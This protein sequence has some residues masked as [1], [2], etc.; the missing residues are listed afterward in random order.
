MSDAQELL[1]K[2][3][4]LAAV[5]AEIVAKIQK[6][7]STDRLIVDA[8]ILSFRLDGAQLLIDEQQSTT[9]A[10]TILSSWR[11]PTAPKFA[12]DADMNLFNDNVDYKV[13]NLSDLERLNKKIAEVAAKYDF[14]DAKKSAPILRKFLGN[15][16]TV[17]TLLG[18]LDE[19]FIDRTD[20]GIAEIKEDAAEITRAIGELAKKIEARNAALGGNG[21]V[22]Q[23]PRWLQ[24]KCGGEIKIDG[25]AARRVGRSGWGG[26]VMAN[27]VNAKVKFTTYGKQDH[28]LWGGLIGVAVKSALTGGELKPYS[29]PNVWFLSLR[30]G[31]KVNSISGGPCASQPYAVAV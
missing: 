15:L 12:Q 4:A 21:R 24:E 30:S 3:A 11:P 14:L 19:Q 22:I 23:T 27:V 9:P 29:H 6:L 20:S 28:H 25:L 5:N 7:A 17:Q 8:R 1:G 2:I 18:S 13:E 10:K 26:L 31:E 16:E